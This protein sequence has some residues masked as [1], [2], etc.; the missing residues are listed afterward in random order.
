MT[1]LDLTKRK[2]LPDAL[3]VLLDTFPREDWQNDPGY[4][5]L[6]SFWL[7]RHLMFRRLLGEMTNETEMLLDKKSDARRFASRVSRY[8]SMFVEQLHG[9]HQ[10]EDQ[11]YFPVLS[12]RDSRLKRGFEMLDKDHHALDG[13][14]NGFVESANAVLGKHESPSDL[15]PAAHIFR[16]D[17]K[18]L[19]GFIDRHLTDEEDLIVPVILKYGTHGL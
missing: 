3:R 2:E 5:G 4:N 16:K 14:L 13:L 12:A 19:S 6:I 9:H 18:R 11:H 7:E 17:V 8:G 10:I 1:I 15:V